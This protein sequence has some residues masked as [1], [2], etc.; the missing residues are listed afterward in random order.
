[1]HEMRTIFSEQLDIQDY[2]LQS[3]P[4]SEVCRRL[5][6]LNE[7]RRMVLVKD[8]LTPLDIANRIMRKDNYMIAM[9]NKDVLKLDVYIPFVGRRPIMTKTLEWNLQMTLA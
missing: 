9:V 7:K 5:I 4:W 6:K 3:M 2:D 8:Q 1:M